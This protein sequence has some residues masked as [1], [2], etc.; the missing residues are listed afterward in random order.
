MIVQMIGRGMRLSPGKKD[1]HVIDMVG[2]IRVQGIVT[3]PTLFGLDP[4]E[5]VSE[6][7]P[8][9]MKEWA[10][11]LQRIRDVEKEEM[12][13]GDPFLESMAKSVTYTD[14]ESVQSLLD[15]VTDLN[16]RQISKLAWVYVGDY[17]HILSIPRHGFLRVDKATDGILSYAP[18]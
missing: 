18:T 7:T 12:I 16:V 11:E 5:V 10:D 6:A 15:D 1:C 13:R 9:Q 17:K 8:T 4:N 14:W 3:T 2:T